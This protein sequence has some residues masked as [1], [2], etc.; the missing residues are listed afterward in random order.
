MYRN[1]VMNHQ[2]NIKSFVHTKDG[3]K[4]PS[5]PNKI[6]NNFKMIHN[7][8]MFH[9]PVTNKEFESLLELDLIDQQHRIL[10]KAYIEWSKKKDKEL[11]EKRKRAR[12]INEEM[13]NNSH[14]GGPKD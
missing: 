11:E 2:L 4:I 6:M 9:I 12:K 8:K 3:K 7:E 10:E 14:I 1:S 13:E 5:L